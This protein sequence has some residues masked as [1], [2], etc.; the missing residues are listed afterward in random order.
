MW[1][2]LISYHFWSSVLSHWTWP[3]CC[4]PVIK[5]TMQQI[6]N[7][8]KRQHMSPC[9][10][11]FFHCFYMAL[12]LEPYHNPPV[13]K[14]LKNS[15]WIHLFSFCQRLLKQWYL[16]QSQNLGWFYTKYSV[17]MVKQKH[18]RATTW[19]TQVFL[20]ILDNN[21]A[22]QHRGIHVFD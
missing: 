2:I 7:L 17:V 15:S 22:L 21:G 12:G 11:T 13:W 10:K 9:N 19:L 18:V 4:F 3:T 6:I 1:K 8:I 14:P 16:L 20:R 5:L